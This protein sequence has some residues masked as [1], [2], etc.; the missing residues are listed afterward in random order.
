MS[1]ITYFYS[2]T[3]GFAYIGSKQL[4]HISSA[5]G[6]QIEHKPF[7]LELLINAIGSQRRE[8]R[9]LANRN[10]FFKR[11]LERWSEYRG[12][13]IMK[14]IPTFYKESTRIANRIL[15][16]GLVANCN[17][18]QLSHAMMENLWLHDRNLSEQKVLEDI[19][20]SVDLD[21]D[22]LING[23][24]S[25]DVADI[26]ESN[27]MKA[28]SNPIFGSP[29]YFVGDDMFFGQDRL[30]LVERAIETPFSFRFAQ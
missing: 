29:T 25:D 26:Y 21:P 1:K 18:D 11:E 9:T 27:T 2:A 6:Y 20:I 22:V 12:V 8:D 24:K 7:D 3:S 10:Y 16:S 17:I 13:S 4:L 19:I 5:T 15:I 14:H 28:I 23:S 30:E